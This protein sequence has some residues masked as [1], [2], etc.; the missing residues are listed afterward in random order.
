[1]Q[2]LANKKSRH[3]GIRK[4]RTFV[5]NIKDGL[6]Q[7]NMKAKREMDL[8]DE[9]R[10][11]GGLSAF[12]SNIKS[13]HNMAKVCKI[14]QKYAQYGKNVPL[15]T[16]PTYPDDLLDESMRSMAKHAKYGKSM[17]LNT[18]PTQTIFSAPAPTTFRR[19]VTSEGTRC[20]SQVPTIQH[21]SQSR[22]MRR[23]FSATDHADSGGAAR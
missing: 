11:A 22:V 6:T 1:M 21:H 15:S 12:K 20:K 23:A 14:R 8:S 16:W 2:K 4:I 5:N 17:P 18:W 3:A 13:M 19:V 9:F 7:K 10:W